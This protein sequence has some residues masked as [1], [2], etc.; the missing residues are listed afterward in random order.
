VPWS[1]ETLLVGATVEDAGFDESTSVEGV[2]Q[3]TGA[4]EDLL[5][6]ARRASLQSVRV[7]L[8]PASPD[9]RPIIG[10][11]ASAPNVILA[12]GH[13][14]N[15]I[16]LAPLTA[17]MVSRFLLDAEHDPA[18]AVTSPARFDSE[19]PGTLPAPGNRT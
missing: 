10:P 18:L 5:P 14:R 12:T 11:L 9:G 16:L 17:A 2:R 13:Y 6:A 15:G 1:D 4:V 8:R 7:G 19:S 3:L